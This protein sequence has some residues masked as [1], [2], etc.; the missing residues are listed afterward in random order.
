ML[1]Q[2]KGGV[3]KPVLK[4]IIKTKIVK[5]DSIAIVQV[6]NDTIAIVPIKIVPEIAKISVS[7][8][9]IVSNQANLV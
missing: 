5:R 4:D 7:G 8:K 9:L 3:E 6:K 2:K 1:M